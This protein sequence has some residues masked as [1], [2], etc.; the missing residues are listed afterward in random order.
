MRESAMNTKIF[1]A[2]VAA[3]ILVTP[4][5]QADIVID[6]G[7]GWQATIFNENQVDLIVDLVDF[8]Q[9]ILVLQKFADFIEIDDKTGLPAALS[10]AFEQIAPDEATISHILLTD[11][12]LINHTGVNWSS[13]R[14]I[15][16]GS[17][18]AFD[19]VASADFSID[20]FTQ[21][22]FNGDNTEVNFSGGL[23]AD[24]I[25]WTPGL[26][27]GALYIDIDLSQDDPVAFI[28]KELPVPAPGA[29]VLLAF[30]A[31][32]ANRRRRR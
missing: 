22:S 4:I 12:F 24:G 6:L 8:D 29:I 20:P 25:N 15:L 7:G 16:L 23:I 31:L 30:P 5:A 1:F 14:D 27:S 2:V 32:S 19:P 18:A 10:I 3:A 26:E 11:M 9:D 13:F 28:L 17:S 21:M